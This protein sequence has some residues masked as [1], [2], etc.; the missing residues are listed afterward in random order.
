MISG[1]V[2]SVYLVQEYYAK[3]R[4]ISAAAKCSKTK[5]IGIQH[6]SAGRMYYQ[7]QFSPLET[8]MTRSFDSM[9]KNY[10]N[11]VPIPNYTFLF[12][13]YHKK[14][15]SKSDGYPSS[16]LIITGPLRNDYMAYKSKHINN[17][18]INNIKAEL[19]IHT[20]EKLLLFCSSH[21]LKTSIL[22]FLIEAIK[23]SSSKPLLLIKL[24][25]VLKEQNRYINYMN[26]NN[27]KGYKFVNSAVNKLLIISDIVTSELSNVAYESVLCNKPH[28]VISK[29]INISDSPGFT[30]EPVIM[31]ADTSLRAGQ[32]IDM[33]IRDHDYRKEFD[34]YR[35]SF[36][37][38]Y[39]NNIDGKTIK[40]LAYNIQRNCSI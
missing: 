20:D 7:Y 14:V 23:L 1:N 8:G 29:D 34:K 9:N 33:S 11:Y 6:G 10:I 24:H 3:S 25:P 4:L 26:E 12:G 22:S 2:E 30:D 35:N 19:N 37:L 15:I 39:F 5:I 13:S 27:Y 17:D 36:L 32:I 21:N 16:R 31:N 18:E 38:K 28:L 40:R